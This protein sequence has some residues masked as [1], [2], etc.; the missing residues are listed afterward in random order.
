MTVAASAVIPSVSRG[1][2]PIVLEGGAHLSIA[3]AGFEQRWGAWQTRGRE[4]E[5]ASRQRIAM[6]SEILL[7]LLL[8]L[9]ALVFALRPL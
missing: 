3:D 8:V 5:R 9:S 4:R 2:P 6:A 1:V 7:A